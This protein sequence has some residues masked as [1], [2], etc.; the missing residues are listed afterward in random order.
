MS[1]RAYRVIKIEYARPDSFNL[2]HDEKLMEFLDKEYGFYRYLDDD[3]NGLTV[4]PL[5]ALD[6]AIAEV[7]MEDD[8]KE[9]LTKD[10]ETCRKEG[11]EYVQYYCF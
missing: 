3:C 10:I 11:E 6:R 8:V 1:V 2:S 5:E 4:F 9:A 7:E